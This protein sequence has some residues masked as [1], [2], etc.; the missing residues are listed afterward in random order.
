MKHTPQHLHR[1][2]HTRIGPLS[3]KSAHVQHF[4][5]PKHDFAIPERI[6]NAST[7]EPLSLAAIWTTPTRPGAMDAYRLP[8]LSVW[9]AR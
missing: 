9:G 5:E 3:G 8:S 1:A 4:R 2:S 6:G 7:R